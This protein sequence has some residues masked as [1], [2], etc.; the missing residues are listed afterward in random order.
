MLKNLSVCKHKFDKTIPGELT[1]YFY[2]IWNLCTGTGT[3]RKFRAVEP[4]GNK[5]RKIWIDAW[6]L[7]VIV[8]LLKFSK[9]FQLKIG[10]ET[11]LV[12]ADGGQSQQ[13]LRK[14][15]F[16]KSHRSLVKLC[17]NLYW[18]RQLDPD[19]QKNNA[20][21][22]PSTRDRIYQQN[23]F[24]LS[25]GEQALLVPDAGPLNHDEVLLHLTVVRETAHRVNRLV[26]QIV[27]A[28]GL[29]NLTTLC[30]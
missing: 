7:L 3:C 6:K 20:D 15:F 26:G 19:P 30:I 10:A 8:I 2:N 9:Q 14:I 25:E 1:I 23:P 27:P 13:S 17:M 29:K 24:Y 4:E 12:G 28:Q 18:E 5:W 16:T 21:P 22:Q 11:Q